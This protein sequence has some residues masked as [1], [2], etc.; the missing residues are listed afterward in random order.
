MTKL[1]ILDSYQIYKVV[2]SVYLILLMF[3][4]LFDNN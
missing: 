3:V 4:C 2:I 1:G